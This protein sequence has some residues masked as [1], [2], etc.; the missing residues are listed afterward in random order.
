VSARLLVTYS[1]ILLTLAVG[2]CTMSAPMYQGAEPAPE[3][4]AESASV[5]YDSED[6]DDA[7]ADAPAADAAPVEA[8]RAEEV[9]MEPASQPASGPPPAKKAEAKTRTAA[10]GRTAPSTPAAAPPVAQLATLADKTGD[11]A[12][13]V[14]DMSNNTHTDHGVNPF[15]ITTEDRLS[16]FSIDVDT[17]SYTLARRALQSRQLPQQ[18]SVRVEEFVNYFDYDS[19]SGP[20][21]D[22]PFAVHMEAMPDPFRQGRHILRVGVQGKDVDR[23]QR[24]AVHLTFLVDVSGSMSSADKLGMAKK[25]L[26]M[27]VDQLREDDTVALATYAGRTARVLEPTTALNKREIHAAIENL[28]AGGSTAMSS[29]IDIAYDMAAQSFQEGHENRVVVLSDGDANV[30]RTSWDDM[31]SQIKG[32]ADRGITLS[33]IGLGT[34]NYRDTLMEQLANKGDGNNFYIDSQAQA[35]RV[36]VEELPGTMVTIARDVKI[37]VEFHPESVKAYR[38][39]G[40]ENRAIADRDFRNDRVDAGEIGANH[41]V[42]AL[43]EVILADNYDS[44]LATVR[45]RWEA[46]GA[47]KAASERAYVFPEQALRESTAL[48]SKDT[49]IAYAAGTFAEILRGSPHVSELDLDSLMAFTKDSLRSGEKDDLELLSLMKQARA[50]GAGAQAVATRR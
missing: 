32:H 26:H 24:E 35:Q 21:D 17:A 28:S 15:T 43:Y 49:R 10:S 19:Y 11:E 5:T 13:V 3:L 47:D 23:S 14:V 36:F 7:S 25:A 41:N 29:G 30:G 16:T 50:L 34:G 39:I 38:L 37:Q 48:T 33:T 1:S 31:L 6:N 9:L 8:E 46:P 44:E 20:S 12:D 45:M 18:A 42:T 22:T 2:A 27:M 4:A 40:Y